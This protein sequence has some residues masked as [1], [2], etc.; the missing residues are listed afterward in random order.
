MSLVV[1]THRCRYPRRR[2]K[3]KEEDLC[4][5]RTSTQGRVRVKGNWTHRTG[6]DRN[7]G[8]EEIYRRFP[9]PRDPYRTRE[10]RKDTR[11]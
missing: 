6:R 10:E 8:V 1:G 9:V 2:G 7:I 5:K 3:V 11:V 4:E